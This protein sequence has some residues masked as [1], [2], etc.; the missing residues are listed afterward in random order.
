MLFC[1]SRFEEGKVYVWDWLFYSCVVIV[2]GVIDTRGVYC[3][4]GLGRVMDGGLG[5]LLE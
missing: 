2:C 3:G 1:S 5:S 4:C